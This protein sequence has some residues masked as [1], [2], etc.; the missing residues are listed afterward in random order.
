MTNKETVIR[1]LGLTFDFVKHLIGCPELTEKLPDD[2]IL[3]FAEKDFAH[4][5]KAFKPGKKKKETIVKVKNSFELLI[6]N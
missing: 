3:E 5:F 1:N 2:F 4:S 6:N